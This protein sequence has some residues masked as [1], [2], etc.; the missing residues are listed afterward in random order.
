MSLRGYSFRLVQANH[1][2]D[3]KRIGV[4]LGRYCISKDIPVAEVAEKFD[5]SRMT[6]YSWFTGVSD[7]HRSKAEQIAAMLKRARFSV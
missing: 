4:A 6:I 3:S 7:P 1:T 2:A 5:V